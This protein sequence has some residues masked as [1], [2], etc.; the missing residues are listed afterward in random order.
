LTILFKVN[1]EKIRK[2]NIYLDLLL[3][4]SQATK[5]E[6]GAG[7]VRFNERAEVVEVAKRRT[8]NTSQG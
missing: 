6:D 2:K 5:P 4:F 3:N 7:G 1:L 8:S